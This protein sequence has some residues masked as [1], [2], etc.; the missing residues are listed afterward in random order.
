MPLRICNVPSTFLRV[1]NDAFR[2]FIDDFLIVY[3]EDILIFNKSWEDHVNHAS[4]VLDVL[5][6]EKLCL[7]MSK[8][9]FGKT[10]LVYLGYIV[11]GGELKLIPLK[12]N[13][14]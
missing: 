2:P 9:E 14:L 5:K 3:L 8:S 7:K 10:C 11:A 12:L 1:M 4:K 6:K 13:P